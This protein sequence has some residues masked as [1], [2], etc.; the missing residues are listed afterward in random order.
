MKEIIKE[1]VLTFAG[2]VFVPLVLAV[3]VLYGLLLLVKWKLED[4]LYGKRE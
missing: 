2:F 1:F 4:V 3:G